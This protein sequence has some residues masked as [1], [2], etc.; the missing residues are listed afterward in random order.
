MTSI[1][2]FTIV[3]INLYETFRAIWYHLHKLKNVKNTREGVL[4]K[5]T[6]LQGCSSRFLNFTNGTKSHKASHIPPLI[7]QLLLQNIR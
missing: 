7:G 2:Y 6:I 4:L 1:D 5:V 3:T